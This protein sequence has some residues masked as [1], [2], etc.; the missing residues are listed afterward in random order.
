MVHVQLDISNKE[1]DT[2]EDFI[3]VWNL[4]SKHNAAHVEDEV[5]YFKFTRNCHE[6]KQINEALKKAT[7][8]IWVKL[9]NA[10]EKVT[11]K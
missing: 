7:F 1:I 8:K 3:M 11:E 2:M 9:V 10:Y 6:C 4:C 5:E